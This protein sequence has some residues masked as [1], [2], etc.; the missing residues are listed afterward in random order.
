M[1]GDVHHA[2]RTQRTPLPSAYTATHLLRPM[3]GWF[4]T[5]TLQM[6]STT[7][8]CLLLKHGPMSHAGS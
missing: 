3:V 5:A 6:V 1:R 8:F 2:Q 7:K 4:G